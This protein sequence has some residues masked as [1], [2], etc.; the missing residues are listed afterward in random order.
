MSAAEA[1]MAATIRKGG[2]KSSRRQSGSRRLS[3]R[4]VKDQ[5]GRPHPHAQRQ[6]LSGAREAG[7]MAQ[8]LALDLHVREDVDAGELERAKEAAGQQHQQNDGCRRARRK[9]RARGN[10]ARPDERGAEEYSL[11]TEAHQQRV[12]GEAHRQRTGR[13]RE[14]Q[15]SRLEGIQAERDLQEQRQQERQCT[16]P[17]TE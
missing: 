5:R 4:Q 16:D 1:D 14:G 3:D 12:R 15:E 17:D 13:R 8:T 9:G 7:R 10:R 2:M 11:E 6:L